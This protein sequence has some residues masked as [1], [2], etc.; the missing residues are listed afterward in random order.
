MGTFPSSYTQVP[1]PPRKRIT[2][3]SSW[4]HVRPPLAV[5][6][7]AVGAFGITRKRARFQTVEMSNL[8]NSRKVSSYSRL[9]KVVH[10]VTD[11]ICVV[12]GL[13][14]FVQ[15]TKLP[16]TVACNKHIQWKRLYRVVNIF[17]GR[18]MSLIVN[19]LS[20][21]FHVISRFNQNFKSYAYVTY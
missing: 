5:S 7:I 1:L 20:K 11:Y 18:Y 13:A 14:S 21:M 9:L 12:T 2:V 8:C 16:S 6:S 17:V 19:C 10:T 15:R 4:N 3:K